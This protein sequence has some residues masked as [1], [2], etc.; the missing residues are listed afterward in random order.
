MAVVREVIEML[1]KR[2]LDEVVA[3]IGWWTREDVETNNHM[4]I[5]DDNWADIVQRQEDDTWRHIDDII[6]EGF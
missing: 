2:D 1:S 6:G 4:T 5:G 3:L